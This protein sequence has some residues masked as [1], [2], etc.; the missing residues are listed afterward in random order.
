MAEWISH[1]HVALD[2]TFSTYAFMA[3]GADWLAYGHFVIAVTLFGPIRDPLRNVWVIDFGILAC[4]L[5][6]SYALIF[7]IVREIPFFWT[8]IDS[9]FEL[10]GL[11]PLVIAHRWVGRLPSTWRLSDI[12]PRHPIGIDPGWMGLRGSLSASGNAL[13]RVCFALFHRAT[14]LPSPQGRGDSRPSGRVFEQTRLGCL[15]E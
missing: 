15:I 10:L 4:I 8:L 6:V 5:L 14:P 11:V 9:L 7:G 13:S 3:Y 2:G 12:V 1:A